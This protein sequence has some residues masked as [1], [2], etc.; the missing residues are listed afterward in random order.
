MLCILCFNRNFDKFA[1]FDEKLSIYIYSP[2]VIWRL[3]IKYCRVTNGAIYFIPTFF[4]TFEELKKKN[5][6]K[7]KQR[8]KLIV[9][10]W[11]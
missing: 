7:K 3:V 8:L 6:K 11:Q 9:R 1:H 4:K 5:R 2:N 10:I